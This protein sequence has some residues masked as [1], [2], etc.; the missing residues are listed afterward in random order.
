MAVSERY[1]GGRGSRV[2]KVTFIGK[3]HLASCTGEPFS[4]LFL[5]VLNKENIR[6]TFKPVK[7]LGSIF[8]ELEDRS[9]VNQFKGIMSKFK[10]ARGVISFDSLI[11]TKLLLP[12]MYPPLFN[13]IYFLFYRSYKRYKGK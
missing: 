13:S 9:T 4:G 10:Y 11:Q 7:T 1:P 2:P 5:C 3:L 8:K 6:T 12:Y